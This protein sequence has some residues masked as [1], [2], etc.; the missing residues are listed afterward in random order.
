[1]PS[2][3]NPTPDY[4]VELARAGELASEVRR[5]ALQHAG[6]E[7]GADLLARLARDDAATL[8]KLPPERVAAEVARRAGRPRRSRARWAFVPLLAASAA[9]ALVLSPAAPVREA[10][11]PPED[12]VRAK[13]HGATRLV[14]HRRTRSGAEVMAPGAR[15]RAGDLVQLGYV[16]DAPYGVIVSID[17]RGA[18]TRHWPLDGDEA[19]AL[20]SGREVLLPESFRLDDAPAFE[21]FILVTA[22]RPFEVAGVVDAARI[23]AARADARVARLPLA[24]DLSEASLVVS[25]EL[26]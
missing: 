11:R 20:T 10:A 14:V 15:A 7:A 2:D 18:V 6:R 9:A 16:A 25:K 4:L 26:P 1:M 12:G 5:E 8:A 3:R 23:L 17:G 22:G 13:G 21:R 24:P 19:G